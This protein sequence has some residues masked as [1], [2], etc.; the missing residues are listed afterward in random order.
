MSPIHWVASNGPMPE[1]VTAEEV[2]H[3]VAGE[4]NPS[5]TDIEGVHVAAPVRFG[6]GTPANAVAVGIDAVDVPRLAAV[7]E[8]TPAM[9]E[10]CFTSTELVDAA[11]GGDEIGHLGTCFAAKEAVAKAL[12]CGLGPVG[13][14][15]VELHRSASGAPTLVLS[16]AAVPLAEAAGIASWLVS[17][18]H[19]DAVAQTVV[20]ALDAPAAP[21]TD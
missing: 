12:G 19:T 11:T 20:I 2:G 3:T 17:A 16:G 6:G 15:D 14:H 18:T 7:L 5:G 1:R 8:R 9:R 4:D 10:R 21:A 13:F